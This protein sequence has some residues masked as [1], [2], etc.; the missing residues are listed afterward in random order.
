MSAPPPE[1]GPN[2]KPHQE[3]KCVT[4]SRNTVYYYDDGPGDTTIRPRRPNIPIFWPEGVPFPWEKQPDQPA[5]DQPPPA[6]DAENSSPEPNDGE[7]P[8]KPRKQ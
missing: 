8:D 7:G 1:N 4:E 5:K 3:Q 2:P 6:D